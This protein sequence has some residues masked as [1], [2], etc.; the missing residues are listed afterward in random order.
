MYELLVDAFLEGQALQF[1][2]AGL[3][4][5]SQAGGCVIEGASM[6]ELT[7]HTRIGIEEQFQD[8][9]Q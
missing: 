5:G 8:R 1:G 9:M 2:V 4:S 7:C 3:E 6:Y